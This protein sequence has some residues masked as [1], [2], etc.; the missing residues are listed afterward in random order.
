MKALSEGNIHGMYY[1]LEERKKLADFIFGEGWEELLE[2]APVMV[3]LQE[4]IGGDNNYRGL[5]A[6]ARHDD[7]PYIFL[8]LSIMKQMVESMRV[9]VTPVQWISLLGAKFGHEAVVEMSQLMMREVIHHELVHYKQVMNGR[10]NMDD[11]NHT[12]WEGEDWGALSI[13]TTDHL[14]YPWELEAREHT[15]S[16][17]P[18]PWL[19][20]EI[21]GEL[22]RM[23][24]TNPTEENSKA[25][26]QIIYHQLMDF[27]EEHKTW[28]LP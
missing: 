4:E 7:K 23:M 18:I 21:G 1:T 19:S 17:T 27:I 20:G 11:V 15:R 10:L 26:P 22:D 16:V 5:V 24:N 12:I 13:G 28:K 2:G 9:V 3:C 25:V 14:N 6:N 8:N